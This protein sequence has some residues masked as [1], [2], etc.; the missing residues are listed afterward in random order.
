MSLPG[1]TDE[2][3]DAILDWIDPDDT[4]R[5][6]GAEAETYRTLG[7]PYSPRNGV[8][9]CLEELLLVR[10]VTRDL[11]FGADANLNRQID[12]EE[13]RG[14]D[15]GGGR[16]GR[17]C[18]GLALDRLQRRAQRDRRWPAAHRCEPE[19]PGGPA[20]RADR[21]DGRG[22]GRFHRPLPPVRALRRK[23]ARRRR[24]GASPSR[25]SPARCGSSLSLTW[26]TP[27]CGLSPKRARS[28]WSWP[29]D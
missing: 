13:G 18:L 28:H 16:V 6:F 4:P 15:S 22:L 17:A 7:V 19:R 25:A 23:R 5:Q 2:V 10:G 21:R 26:W 12:P 3:A 1:M 9:Q 14:A 8:P 29:A 20:Q 11:L 27:R 24:P